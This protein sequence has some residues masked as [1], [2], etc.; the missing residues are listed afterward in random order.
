[1]PL[2]L[3]GCELYRN[4][5]EA[6]CLG[7]GGQAEGRGLRPRLP[8]GLSAARGRLTASPLRPRRLAAWAGPPA[9]RAA[10][11][12]PLM[13]RLCRPDPVSVAA[14]GRPVSMASGSGVG[15][16]P[17]TPTPQRTLRGGVPTS[18]SQF[19][20]CQMGRT[21]P[22]QRSRVCAEAALLSA[23]TCAPSSVPFNMPVGSS[24]FLF[25]PQAAP[26]GH[27]Q[28]EGIPDGASPQLC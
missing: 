8:T 11:E 16:W 2:G 25:P 21:R 4:P 28:K 5:E 17:W 23:D 14:R 6:C 3:P 18:E 13:P 26:Q 7:E 1:M 10:L 9:H 12:P 24:G 20:H 15:I 27:G 22:L 19:S